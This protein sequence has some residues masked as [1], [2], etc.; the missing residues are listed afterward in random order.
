MSTEY[1]LYPFSPTRGWTFTVSGKGL[2][3]NEG[4]F[5]RRHVWHSEQRAVEQLCRKRG[6]KEVYSYLD[7]TAKLTH[8]GSNESAVWLSHLD[9]A[10]MFALERWRES[11][12]EELYRDIAEERE[13]AAKEE[14]LQAKVSSSK[15]NF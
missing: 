4:G 8:H 14:A 11:S 13:R 7:I 5:C 1:T 10:S 3:P 2:A 15:Q 12:Y 9:G 6:P